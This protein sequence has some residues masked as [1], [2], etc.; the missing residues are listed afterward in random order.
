MTNFLLRL[1]VKDYQNADNPD[2]HSAIGKL[3]GITGI[4]CNCLLSA[5]KLIA[6]LIT[7]SVAIIADAINNLS[8]AASSIVTL[9]GFRLAQ[10]PADKKHPYGHARYE[11]LSGLA[12]AALI[13]LIGAELVKSSFNKIIHPVPVDFS[14]VTFV[15]L[16]C[17]IAVKLWMSRFY[18]SLGK[19]IQST[20][21]QATSVD[22]RN[23]VVATS[24]V[25][26]GG[27]ICRFFNVNIDGYIGLAVALF[28]IHSGID[29]AKDTISPLL[30]QQADE[31]LTAKISNLIQ[32]HEKVLGIHDLLVHDYGPGQ[33]YASVHVELNG[34]ED[35]LVCH[36]II[37]DI[38]CDVSAELN[39]N[40]VIHYDPILP[41][42]EEWNKMRQLTEQIVR[43]IE[44]RLS[45]HDFRMIKGAKQTRLTFDLA[46]PYDMTAQRQ[47]I[48]Q[49]IDAAL[50][51]DREEYT[52]AI[53][54]D[55]KA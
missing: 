24:S 46:V 5:G 37:D 1:F 33:C 38:E 42:D 16:L 52:T 8:D 4:V 30:G 28:I 12:V 26:I 53:R 19:R 55:G 6:G 22:S 51:K 48:K 40:L 10:R 34:E 50:L 31:E 21:L 43:E 35:P 27:L 41:N 45:M 17:S 49:K 54:F 11:Y 18:A 36:D 29:I 23:D 25:L 9:M 39:V 47:E 32:S 15:I 44:P 13:L 20:T 3:A 14:L 7:G 2:V